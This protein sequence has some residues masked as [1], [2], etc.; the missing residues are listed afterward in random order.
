VCMQGI[1]LANT[2][3]GDRRTGNSKKGWH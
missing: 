2:S 1:T 3:L